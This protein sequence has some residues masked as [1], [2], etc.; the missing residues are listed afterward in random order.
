MLWK[1]VQRTPHDEPQEE[2][3]ELEVKP[4]KSERRYKIRISP[5]P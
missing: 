3:A 5:D 2:P 4:Q 1:A